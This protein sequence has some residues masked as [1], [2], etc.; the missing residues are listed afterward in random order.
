MDKLVARMTGTVEGLLILSR[1]DAGHLLLE[2]SEVTVASL[3]ETVSEV[4]RQ[5]HTDGRVTFECSA[6]NTT[7][8]LGD[9]LL[10][11]IAVRNLVENSL[12]YAP[13]GSIDIRVANCR[14][15]SLEIRVEDQGP[16]I[17]L[18]VLRTYNAKGSDER[19]RAASAGR[20]GGPW[21]LHR[22]SC[23]R[24]PWRQAFIRE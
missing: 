1:A 12:R 17:P 20:R 13:E 10:L 21:A 24:G 19:R 9:S 15:G 6:P 3:S 11:A 5:L 14:E 8:I 16:G 7:K 2:A 22:S 23:C 4:V 18:E